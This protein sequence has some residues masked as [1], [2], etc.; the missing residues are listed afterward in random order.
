MWIDATQIAAAQR[1]AVAV[2]EFENLDGDFAAVFDAIAKLRSGKPPVLRAARHVEDDLDHFRGDRTGKG[3]VMRN[4]IGGAHA[5]DPL[6]NA[7]NL[8]LLGADHR[9]EIAHPR[10]PE[11]RLSH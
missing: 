9:N 11:S 4:L 6:Q 5:R 7:P 1:R 2:E 10:R 8:A 3:M